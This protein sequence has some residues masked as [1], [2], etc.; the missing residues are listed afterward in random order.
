MLPCPSRSNVLCGVLLLVVPTCGFGAEPITA[1]ARLKTP[2]TTSKVVG[3]PEPPHPYRVIRTLPK[4][5]T[6]QALFVINEPGTKRLIFIEHGGSKSR[7]CRTRDDGSSGEFDILL[8][9]NEPVYSACFHPKFASNGFIYLGSNG[10]R[11]GA[12]KQTRVT[13]YT[14]QRKAPFE[15]DPQSAQ[16]IIEWESNGHNGAAVVFGLDG[17]LYVTS[18]DGTSDSDTNITGQGLDHL[19]AKVLRIDVDYPATGKTYSIPKDNPFVNRPGTR[20]ETWA[21]GLRNPW[22]MTVDRKTGHIWV[23][24]NGQDLWEQVYFVR[25]G[26]NYGWSVYEGGHPF[27]LTRKLG[28]DPHVKPAFDHPHSES[29]SLTGGVVY[30][31]KRFPELDGAYIYGD[32]STGKIWA[33]WHNGTKVTRHQEIADSTLQ[34]AGFGVDAAGELLIVDYR[35]KGA[36]F[37]LEPTP[38][39]TSPARFPQ[40]LSESGLFAS[41]PAHVMQ[42]GVVPYSVN[43]PLWSDGAFKL[44]F[45]AIPA[46][47][48]KDGKPPKIGYS[49]NG[50]WSF[51]DRT[52]LVKSFGLETEL[53]NRASRRWIETRFLT[54]TDGEWVGYSY[55]WNEQQT[56]AALVEKSGRKQEFVIQQPDGSTRVQQWSYPSRSDC[57]VCH[58]RAARY[59]LGLTTAQLNRPHHYGDFAANQLE[60]LESLALINVGA[61]SQVGDGFKRALQGEGVPAAEAEAAVDAKSL[62]VARGQSR[63]A[64]VSRLANPYDKTESLE[65]RVRSYLH[66]NCAQCHVGAGGGNA[67]MKLA[68]NTPVSGMNILGEKPLH[69]RYG[70]TSARLVAPGSPEKSIL[71]HRLARRGRGQ[72]PQLATFVVDQ[73]AVN[74]FREWIESLAAE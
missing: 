45:F 36:F 35:T 60:T 49:A 42:P 25:K 44:R 71:L 41:V 65:L 24:N 20:G 16:V 39:E 61:K 47:A 21:Y 57:M 7:V 55:A 1:M 56:D 14:I 72:M 2:L 30:Y 26:D 73:Q 40:K 4:L 5:Q 51:P 10:S 27:Y 9:V 19:L 54:K 17:M 50:S 70:I 31:G 28:P 12:P 62:A 37:T 66:S 48:G 18:G 64:N 6:K 63:Y 29:R 15:L 3:S 23:G 22:R 32:Y 13:R 59:V 11:D 33:G 43:A 74:L 68:F 34:I 46:D 8:D 58:S 69:D 53:G 67:Q 52:V 38:A